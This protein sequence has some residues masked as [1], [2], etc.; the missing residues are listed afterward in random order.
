VYIVVMQHDVAY[1][2]P[3][4]SDRGALEHYTVNPVRDKKF[5]LIKDQLY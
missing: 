1:Q 4:A 3:Y 5:N 2:Q